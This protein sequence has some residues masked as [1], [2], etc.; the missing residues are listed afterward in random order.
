[1]DYKVYFHEEGFKDVAIAAFLDPDDA[2]EW[3]ESQNDELE[4][5]SSCCYYLEK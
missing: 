4:E 2:Q 5:D 3:A 1:M